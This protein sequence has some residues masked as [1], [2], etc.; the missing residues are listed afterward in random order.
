M[1]TTF[2]LKLKYHP[3]LSQ[4]Q[5]RQCRESARGGDEQTYENKINQGSKGTS[6]N[7]LLFKILVFSWLFFYLPTDPSSLNLYIF[8]T[9]PWQCFQY[10]L[11]H[12]LV[13]SLSSF[14]FIP[15]NTV[16]SHH[17]FHWTLV[18][19][20]EQFISIYWTRDPISFGDI[21]VSSKIKFRNKLP[22]G[23]CLLGFQV[24]VATVMANIYCL[25]V[26]QQ[27]RRKEKV[28]LE[29]LNSWLFHSLLY[30][31]KIWIWRTR[32]EAGKEKANI[33]EIFFVDQETS[34][35]FSTNYSC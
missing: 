14:A 24:E 18:P 12:V 23:L 1:N 28:S 21:P 17:Y 26:R 25:L 9:L 31:L 2:F 16:S 11:Y 10:A 34:V 13:P 27:N 5:N 30:N 19:A 7:E 22:S 20:L 15:T 6:E 35:C 4:S 32:G 3:C 8:L 29:S 33:A